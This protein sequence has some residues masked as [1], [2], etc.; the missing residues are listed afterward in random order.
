MA[1]A[2]MPIPWDWDGEDW[3]CWAI[4]WPNSPLWNA[5]LEGFVTTPMK[6]R[7]WDERTGSVQAA[8]EIGREIDRRNHPNEEVLMA[9]NDEI[10]TVFEGILA[11]LTALANK[12]CCPQT[13]TGSGSRGTGGTQQP[14]NPYTDDGELP[15]SGWPQDETGYGQYKTHKCNAA[16]DL[17]DNL[18]YDLTGLSGLSYAAQ[19]PVG[20]V[21][22]LITV[23]LTPV[24]YDD[25]VALAG[26]LIFTGYNYTLLAEM[27]AQ[28]EGAE[29]EIRC[30][31]YN[32]SSAAD[33]ETNL[34]TKLEELADAAFTLEADAA[35]V[36][37]VCSY[38]VTNDALNLIFANVPTNTTGADC[39]SCGTGLVFDICG[40][41]YYN[42]GDTIE[43]VQDCGNNYGCYGVY[44]ALNMQDGEFVGPAAMIEF[45]VVSG[46]IT[47]CTG[48]GLPETW[49]YSTQ[50]EVLISDLTAQDPNQCAG[51][52]FILS[53]VPFS[54]QIVSMTNC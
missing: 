29:D 40:E 22:V 52:V 27:A 15:P 16:Q 1:K 54:V 42:P 28:I 51:Y 25:L 38:M 41:Q 33:A 32:S 6:G 19:T 34:I 37:E 7:F 47:A 14:I 4:E 24:P 17:I 21:G 31:L 18:Q 8:Q 53:D 12:E 46:S 9:C 36:V 44:V 3:K 49:F 20:L 48:R 35:W 23:L 43:A 50:G 26:F 2:R 10:L 39:T 30:I 13:G 11:Q 45:D 5:I